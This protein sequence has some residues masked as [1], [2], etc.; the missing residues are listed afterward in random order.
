METKQ[1]FLKENGGYML[2]LVLAGL[3]LYAFNLHNPLFWDDADWILNNPAVHALTWTNIKFI[4]SHDVLAGIGLVSNYYRPFLF[5]TFLGNW[6]VSGPS[7]VSYH[8]VNNFIHI[9][10]SILLFYL[11]RR[12][13]KNSHAAFLAALV[14][15]IHPLQTEAV[16]YISGRGD[17]LSLLCMLGGIVF[18]A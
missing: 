2:V 9:G 7:P 16:T 11:V 3:F 8:L 13:L 14:F 17:S 18:L 5:L 15:L 6:L 4:F 12:W 1:R 10:N